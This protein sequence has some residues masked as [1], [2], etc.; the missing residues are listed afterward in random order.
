LDNDGVPNDSD[1]CVCTANSSQ[2][3]CDTDGVGD[4]CDAQNVKWVYQRD[5]GQCDWDADNSFGEITIEVYAADQYVNV[6]SG[7]TCFK[8]RKIRW[9]RCLW[10]SSCGWSSSAC[11]DCLS[12]REGFNYCGNDNSCGSTECPF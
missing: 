8:K 12:M 4:A 6:C 5:L 2:T 10:S 1:N 3:D 9:D 11:C 7:T